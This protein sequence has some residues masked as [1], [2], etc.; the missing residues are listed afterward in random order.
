MNSASPNMTLAV[1]DLDG[2][3]TSKCTFLPYL[4]GFAWRRRR[5]VPLITMPFWLAA[6]VCRII[7]DAQVKQ[8]LITSFF[9]G[10]SA[11]EVEQYTAWF[12]ETWLPRHLHR[13]G[14]GLLKE[15]QRAGHRVVLLSAS[16]DMYVNAIGN[17]LGI[18][19]AVSTR[20]AFTDGICE[21]TLAGANCKGQ[22]KVVA[23]SEYL[24]LSAAPLD[25]YAYGDSSHD[26]PVL[27]WA[28]HGHLVRRNCTVRVDRPDVEPV[29]AEIS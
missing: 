29:V 15:H 28:T 9:G 8:K 10:V 7:R 21:G 26:M 5:F 27:M 14:I 12:C 11:D 13:V 24:N 22:Q 19:E 2:T 25:S 17:A 6:Y 23:L 3:L 1:F 16:P 20:V 4:M 18:S